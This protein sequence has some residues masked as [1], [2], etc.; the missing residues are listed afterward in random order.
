LI[1]TQHQKI[2]YSGVFLQLYNLVEATVVRCLNAVSEAAL[3]NKS[4]GASDLNA[5][6]RKEWVRVI[7]KTHADLNYEN[8]LESA[9]ALC[10]HLVGALPIDGFIVER[11]GGGSWDDKL[12]EAV[13]GRLG[14]QLT[15]SQATYSSIKRPFRDELGPLR[16]VMKLRNKL[17]HGEISFAECGENI[18][19]GELRDLTQRTATYLR[20]IVAAF[21]NYIDAHE[22]LQ[23]ASRPA[24]VQ[25]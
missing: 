3:K 23:P 12:I 13:A 17:A 24:Q 15:V 4:W 9:F 25:A 2:L 11:G 16:L 8:R 21:S 14:F 6:L 5:S 20:E 1:T 19:V 10:E 7:A 22:F 18:T